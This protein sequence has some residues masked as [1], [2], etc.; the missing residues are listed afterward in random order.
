MPAFFN[1]SDDGITFDSK[2][3]DRGPEPETLTVG[4]VGSRQYVFI[5]PERIGGVYAYDITDPAA[6][7]FQQY[8]DFRPAAAWLRLI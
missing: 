3:D 5:A 7:T 8:I 1:V 4:S 6:P 2:S